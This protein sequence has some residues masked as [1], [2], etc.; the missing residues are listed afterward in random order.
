MADINTGDTVRLA[1]SFTNSAGAAAD[2]TT[3]VLTLSVN[4][5]ESSLTYG[6]S[7]IVKDS[8]GEYHYDYVVP[9]DLSFY[10]IIYR[11][12]GTGTVTSAQEGMFY[13]VSR[14]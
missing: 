5:V 8:V 13:A 9:T 4:G 10:E 6:A 7:A 1:A 14:L 3:V 2:P 11:W 12:A